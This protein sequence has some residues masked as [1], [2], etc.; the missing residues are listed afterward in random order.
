MSII[1]FRKNSLGCIVTA[2][3][4]TDRL[5]ALCANYIRH[6]EAAL[7]YYAKDMPVD[8]IQFYSAE[9]GRIDI[10]KIV[11]QGKTGHS[12]YWAADVEKYRWHEPSWDL[13]PKLHLVIEKYKIATQMKV[14]LN[15][16]KYPDENSRIEACIDVLTPKNKD[17]LKERRDSNKGV[18]FLENVLHV[19][20][21]GIYSKFTKGTFKFWQAHGEAFDE[22]VNN[23]HK[24]N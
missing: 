20:S 7:L 23:I 6:L 9:D 3:S 16:E 1:K 17:V 5:N 12:L 4:K 14:A 21:L 8:V 22:N 2:K 24:M 19:L 15:N 13:H 10:N 11:N 18:Q